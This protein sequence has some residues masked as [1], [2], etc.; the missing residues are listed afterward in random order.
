MISAAK[1]V[2]H[3]RHLETGSDSQ[4]FWTPIL[5]RIAGYV[6]SGAKLPPVTGKMV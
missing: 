3:V 4:R 1:T 6:S 5:A 2:D